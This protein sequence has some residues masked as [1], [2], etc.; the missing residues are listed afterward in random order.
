MK[1]LLDWIYPK[2]C[3]FCDTIL[4]WGSPTAICSDCHVQEWLQEEPRCRVCS[5]PV[6]TAGAICRSCLVHQIRIP[7]MSLFPYENEVK[8][9]IHRFKYE[10][11]REY[12]HTFGELLYQY[13]GD[14][15]ED[16]AALVPIPVHKERMRSRG[17]NQAQVMAKKLSE[18]SGVPCKE[19]L[20]RVRKTDVQNALSA[21]GR[22][23]NLKGA[24]EAVP[25]E[26]EP[27]DLILIDDIYTSGSTIE[28]AAEE[29]QKVFQNRKIRFLTL[30]MAVVRDMK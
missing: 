5:R 26:L 19:L 10:G 14:G 29:L 4:P 3:V 24:F 11:Q 8:S 21:A 22:R 13:A 20:K 15:L 7:G 2:R 12:G 28:T 16:A 25:M 1:R 30:S 9:A 27:G 6:H 17:Y 18:L 23:K